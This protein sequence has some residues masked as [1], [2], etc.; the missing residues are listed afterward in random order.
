M[1]HGCKINLTSRAFLLVLQKAE[2][3]DVQEQFRRHADSVKWKSVGEASSESAANYNDIYRYIITSKDESG[4]FNAT[5]E[6][7]V[8]RNRW[9]TFPSTM[10]LNRSERHSKRKKDFED[11]PTVVGTSSHVVPAIGSPED[12][13]TFNPLKK[14]RTDDDDRHDHSKLQHLC[15]HGS[16][17]DLID[18]DCDLGMATS[19][20]DRA[21]N[22]GKSSD[23]M[24][25]AVN[26]IESDGDADILDVDGEHHV[27]DCTR[28]DHNAD[29]TSDYARLLILFRDDP[30]VKRELMRSRMTQTR[31][32]LD[33]ND[34][35][36]GIWSGRIHNLFHSPQYK[37]IFNLDHV[38]S[39]TDPSKVP[40]RPRSP[41]QL[42]DMVDVGRKMFMRC[43]GT[44]HGSGYN[45]PSLESFK[46]KVLTVR[47]GYNKYG[48][49]LSAHGKRVLV[50]FE[51]FRLDTAKGREQDSS[52]Q[53]MCRFLTK[54]KDGRSVLIGFEDGCGDY[55]NNNDNISIRR[56]T[57]SG[58]KPVPIK[59]IED[60]TMTEDEFQRN[61]QPNT[62][63]T[64]AL[65]ESGL[66]GASLGSPSN[67]ALGSKYTSRRQSMDG[68]TK[69]MIQQIIQSRDEMSKKAE[70]IEERRI[71]RHEEK[72]K[73]RDD[74]LK[75]LCDSFS[76]HESITNA[77]TVN[78]RDRVML[79]YDGLNRT[80]RIKIAELMKDIKSTEQDGGDEEFLQMLKEDLAD[81]KARYRDVVKRVRMVDSSS[82]SVGIDGKETGLRLHGEIGMEACSK[83]NEKL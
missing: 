10:E 15:P 17:P 16:G 59:R 45:D 57:S 36:D 68:I 5:Y 18:S 50:V 60:V 51:V 76:G 63:E 56:T 55:D 4:I 48:V 80:L 75:I 3:K 20:A 77:S 30:V 13:I 37:P 12:E 21:T 73:R 9:P 14:K 31:T 58:R 39:G 29:Y 32:E 7:M 35:I 43:W 70:I 71:K 11:I 38:V 54:R 62:S 28:P 6:T 52:F 66:A 53:L 83:D 74:R 61:I 49:T 46:G 65:I 33:N 47:E 41:L 25:G 27:V 64:N 22:Q 81:S 67:P 40:T 24:E 19:M 44:Y 2:R 42:R 78:R 79:E 34:N 82:G 23:L 1:I 26:D 69:S 8:H 72:E